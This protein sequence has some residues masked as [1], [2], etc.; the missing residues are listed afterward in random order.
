VASDLF[1]YYRLS[2]LFEELVVVTDRFHLKPLL[3][4]LSGDERF[5]V[6]YESAQ[7]GRW[8]KGCGRR[9]MS[10]SE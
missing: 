10:L 4:L 6:W 5:M 8:C 3:P 7:L 9:V 1:R 2:L